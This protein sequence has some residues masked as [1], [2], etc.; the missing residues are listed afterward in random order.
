[1][2]L[3]YVDSDPWL[4][5]HESCEKLYRQIVEQLN[6]RSFED[7]T[8]GKYAEISA[9]I[10][11]QMKQFGNEIQQLRSKLEQ[12]HSL[13]VEEAERRQRLV[14]T[15]LSLHIQLRQRFNSR[16]IMDNDRG[17]TM[18]NSTDDRERLLASTAAYQP[19][20]T[21]GWALDDDEVSASQPLLQEASA[22]D[23]KL[24]HRVLLKD[25]DENLERL[26]KVI[27][28]QKEI[29]VT[30]GSEIDLQNEI[31]DDLAERMERTNAAIQKETT[32]VSVITRKDSTWGYWMIILLLFFAIVA[33]VLV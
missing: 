32:H 31:V 30:I 21:T 24:D 8:S 28:R 25:Q 18:F 7:R 15:L 14:E 22:S 2:A 13:T 3:V 20:S 26:S 19:V 1:M 12:S 17:H 5:E 10:R 11:L 4:L 27:S 6:L 33:V 16:S 29:S 9:L 23:L